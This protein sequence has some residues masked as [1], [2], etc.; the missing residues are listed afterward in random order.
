MVKL[1]IFDLDGVL[2]EAKKIHYETLNRA[3][4]SFNDRYIIT[5]EEHLNRYDGLK[6]SQK[7]QMLTNEKGLPSE[8][9]SD[10]WNL[11]QKYT[12]EELRNLKRNDNLVETIHKLSSDGYKIACCSNS[13]RK[14][15]LT[16]LSKLEIIEYFDIILSNED[17]K[18]SKPHPEIYWSAISSMSLL[19][20]ET[21]IVVVS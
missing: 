9:H 21:L 7:L 10:V 17:V 8:L 14:T 3:L 13:I 1:I 5:N 11:K 19:P 2:V 6:T 16:V 12:L 20:E 18:N 15:V 4:S